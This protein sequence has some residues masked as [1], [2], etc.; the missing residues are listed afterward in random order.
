MRVGLSE[1][2]DPYGGMGES[3]VQFYLSAT[4]LCG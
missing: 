2:D 1:P 3:L 4:S